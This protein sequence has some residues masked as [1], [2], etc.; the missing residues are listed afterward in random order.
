M[1]VLWHQLYYMVGIECIDL[2]LLK[3]CIF[4]QDIGYKVKKQ[5]HYLGNILFHNLEQIYAHIQ[6]IRNRGAN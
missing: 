1:S 5:V 2:I 4:P 6:I 3:L